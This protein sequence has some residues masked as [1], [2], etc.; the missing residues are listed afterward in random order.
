MRCSGL[1]FFLTCQHWIINLNPEIRSS[2]QLPLTYS[3]A[4]TILIYCFENVERGTAPQ[5]SVVTTE[6]TNRNCSSDVH[7]YVSCNIANLLFCSCDL[8]LFGCF[9]RWENGLK[10]TPLQHPGRGRISLTELVS[11]GMFKTTPMIGKTQ[12]LL[13][14]LILHCI[15]YTIQELT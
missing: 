4:Q 7:M 6:V 10:D 2:A 12:L 9:P 1:S 14:S 3:L 8:L 13:L 11:T 5:I 15:R